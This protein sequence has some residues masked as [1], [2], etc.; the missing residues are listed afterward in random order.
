M[1]RILTFTILLLVS[2]SALNEI[3]ESYPLASM[4]PLLTRAAK[5]KMELPLWMV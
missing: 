4:I 5:L 3:C 1:T 2:P